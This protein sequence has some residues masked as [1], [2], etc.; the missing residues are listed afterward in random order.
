VITDFAAEILTPKPGFPV[1]R[2]LYSAKL[3]FSVLCLDMFAQIHIDVFFN[4]PQI[5]KQ[6]SFLFRQFGII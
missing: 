2:Y 6:L 4:N 1:K 3:V 5:K